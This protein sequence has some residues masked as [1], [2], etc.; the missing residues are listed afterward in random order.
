MLG[1]GCGC[2]VLCSHFL[3]GRQQEINHVREMIRV[4]AVGWSLNI[5]IM[6]ILK[7]TEKNGRRIGGCMEKEKK[8]RRPRTF[9][10][11]VQ[12]S[13]CRVSVLYQTTLGVS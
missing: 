7:R 13:T 6:M 8:R 3:G 4:L 10:Y 11:Q 12:K 1:D 2:L 5:E 9:L